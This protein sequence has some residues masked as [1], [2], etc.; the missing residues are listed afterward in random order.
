V[1]A[2]RVRSV[3]LCAAV[4]VLGLAGCVGTPQPVAS[5]SNA[6]QGRT[7]TIHR[8]E[9]VRITL[10]TTNWQFDPPVDPGVIGW[11]PP[12]VTHGPSRCN[13]LSECGSVSISGLAKLAGRATVHATRERCGE[14]RLCDPSAGSYTLTIEVIA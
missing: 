7:V 8:G 6:D 12:A 2:G 9:P 10:D 5:F 3:A 4:G 11:Q 1:H 13:V 14:L